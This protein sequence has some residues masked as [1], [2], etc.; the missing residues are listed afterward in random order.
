IRC[1]ERMSSRASFMSVH[2]SAATPSEGITST[3]SAGMPALPTHAGSVAGQADPDRIVLPPPKATR[4]G[5]S[6]ERLAAWTS[7]LD[8]VLVGLAL[9]LAFLLGSFAIRNSDFFL[10]L[11]GGRDLLQG[12]YRFGVDPYAYTTDGIYYVN[13][14][15]LFDLGLYGLYQ[16]SGGAGVVIVKALLI[17][18]L[19]GL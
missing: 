10:S 6:P 18:V 5:I 7:R 19:A 2:D 11:A 1:P 13:L 9:V 3:P 17:T 16:L 14:S 12:K 8:R 4:P 15:W